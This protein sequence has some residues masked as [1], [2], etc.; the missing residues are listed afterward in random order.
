VISVGAFLAL[1]GTL[2][3]GEFLAY[4]TLQFG[5]G[6]A[7][8]RLW[9][10]VQSLISA[11][12]SLE[13]MNWFLNQKSTTLEAE[14][15]APVQRFAREIRFENVSFSY[16]FLETQ[17]QLNQINLAVQLGQTVAI[18]GRSGSGKS[19][20][21][22][23]ILRFYDPLEG[24]I[25]FDGYNVRQLN[26]HSLR[27]QIGTVLQENSLF[28]GTITENI[29]LS[30]YKI[31]QAQIEAAARAAEIHDWIAAQPLQYE[32]PVGDQG[33]LLSPGQRQRV[34]LA[35]ALLRNPAILILDEV[36]AAVDPET[37]AGIQATL[38][39][40]SADK[41]RTTLMVTHRLASVVDCDQIFVMDHGQ[42]VE[43]GSHQALLEQRGTYYNLWQLQSGFS[44]SADGR[45][46]AITPQRL[47]AIPL[48]KD[49]DDPLLSSLST[50]FLAEYYEADQIVVAQGDPGDKFYLIVR[51]KVAVY[52]NGFE[53]RDIP[54]GILEDGDYFGEIALVQGGPRSASVK[55]TL[56]SLMLSLEKT[57]FE[58]LLAANESLARAIESAILQRNLATITE[59]GRRARNSSYIDR[60]S[61]EN[62]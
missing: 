57:Q 3:A 11:S 33:R 62:L 50:E 12:T 48:F 53:G 10:F 34:A 38:R 59:R 39:Q 28:N 1:Q 60:I 23:L 25:K 24:V 8:S 13:R 19:T 18:V 32:T 55:T 56:P 4:F 58:R 21:L 47:K 41:S 27:S 43:Q 26:R 16:A 29:R 5:V 31:T 52:T 22:H 35:R 36:T 6:K 46:A 37:E 17:L 49:L 44:V 42:L 9:E 45:H 7:I 51:G 30:N 14:N 61:D 20:L 15:P 40:V 54:L 2:T